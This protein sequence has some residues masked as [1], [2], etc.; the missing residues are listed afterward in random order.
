MS[1]QDK[2]QSVSNANLI[3]MIKKILIVEDEVIIAMSLQNDLKQL[4]YDV[5]GPVVN[6][7]E[8]VLVAFKEKPSLILMDI[9]LIGGMD[10]IDAIQK[11]HEKEYIPIIYMTGYSNKETKERAMKTQP[12]AYLEKPVNVKDVKRILD[13]MSRFK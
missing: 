9:N 8:A 12:L 2:N 13:S 4:G 1:D 7:E 6:G 10:G 5:S 3:I 11:I